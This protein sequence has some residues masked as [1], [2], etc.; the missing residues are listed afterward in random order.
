METAIIA[1]LFRPNTEVVCSLFF[2]G[3]IDMIGK[4]LGHYHITDKLGEGG[5]DSHRSVSVSGC[6]KNWG[7]G[8]S[9]WPPEESK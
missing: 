6:T 4:T 2:R 8:M 5:T 9:T 7:N 1:A 3:V